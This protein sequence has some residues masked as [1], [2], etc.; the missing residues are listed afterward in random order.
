MHSDGTPYRVAVGTSKSNDWESTAYN[1]SGCPCLDDIANLARKAAAQL[2]V[3]GEET[4]TAAG[5]LVKADGTSPH[6]VWKVGKHAPDLGANP[7][8]D[9]LFYAFDGKEGSA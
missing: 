6:V 8:E 7:V 3:A 5:F 9:L 1:I 2:V 4:R